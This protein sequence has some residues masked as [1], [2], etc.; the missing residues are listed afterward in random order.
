VSNDGTRL[1]GI[2]R[3]SSSDAG[4]AL[5][6]DAVDGI[7]TDLSVGAAI[8]AIQERDDHT[9]AVRWR[10]REVSIVDEGADDSV[11]LNRSKPAAAA[12]PTTEQSP[13][14]DQDKAPAAAD[15]K[16]ATP[17]TPTV[18]V[19]RG[20]NAKHILELARYA[21]QRAPE[22]GILRMGED[23]AAFDKPFPEFRAEVWRLMEAR[24]AKQ[25]QPAPKTEVGLS[26]REAQQFS[27]VRAAQAAVTG[28]WKKAGF[29][30][31]V[32]RA[33]ADKLG[34]QPQGFFVPYEVQRA[35]TV[36]EASAGGYLVGT[37]HRGDM[38]I[39]SLRARSIA[40]DAG[41]TAMTGLNG[42]VA[43]PKQ[44]ADATFGWRSENEGAVLSDLGF[45][46]V[47]M[48]PRTLSGGVRMSRRLLMQS[49]PDV[50]TLV[51]NDMTLGAALAIDLAVFEGAG[52]DGEPL[53][54]V[55]HPDINTVAVSTDTTP[56]WDEVVQFESA[57]AT[58][59][60]LAGALKYVTTP[61]VR[62][63]MKVTTK[64]SGSG[65]FVC[66]ENNTVNGYPV[67]T[68]TQL[69]TSRLLFGDFS[70]IVVGMWGVLDIK[71]DDK[72]YAAQG[73]LV[74][75]VFQDVDIAV[76]HAQAFAMGT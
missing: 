46:M 26:E 2:M 37:D 27:I 43:I 38:F 25:P 11:G 39:E 31:E 13:M 23:Y 53:G 21:D 18:G 65:L 61:A 40:F 19:D 20:E 24:Q 8:Y 30:L 68:S 56:T 33:I 67:L 60:A 16:P 1:R 64:D 29:E 44:T 58:D 54:L 22:L 71:P 5:Y 6:R 51:R 12:A 14:S 32:S 72:T 15:P 74:L 62:G 63:K 28:N 7:L 69:A 48:T 73:G 34:R 70:Q 66:S 4:R 52:A 57:V 3:F 49:S 76:R 17:E 75:W 10:P 35:M 42:N 9:V 55:N 47:N 41:A 50:E 45:G 59:N 36:G